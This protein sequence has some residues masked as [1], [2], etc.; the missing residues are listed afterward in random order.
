MLRELLSSTHRE[1]RPLLPTCANRRGSVLIVEQSAE[2]RE[3]LRTALT[4][5]GI[6]TLEA[7]EAGAGLQLLRDFRPDVVVLDLD[8]ELADQ[9]SIRDAFDAEG[10][11]LIVLGTARRYLQTLPASRVHRKPYHY[12]PLIRTIET[13]CG[14]TSL[15]D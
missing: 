11:T 14:G 4:R 3:V 6:A 8:A 9:E 2:S 5:R 7:E 10:Q 13:L 12:G 15:T 1:V